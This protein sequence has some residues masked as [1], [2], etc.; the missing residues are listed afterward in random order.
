MLKFINDN[1]VLFS[2]VFSI[3]TA[4]IA[5]IVAIIID[6]KKSKQDTIR[7]L[8]KELKET[9][10]ELQQCRAIVDCYN[11]IEN[12]EKNIDKSN[13]AIYV[14]TLPDGKKRNICGY[15]WEN[16]HIKSPL[17]T[18]VSFSTTFQQTRRSGY[19]ALCKT[20]CYDDKVD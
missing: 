18:E 4:L 6:N 12:A 14:E 5:A 16:K 3:I 1:G 15:C 9:N 13:G 2:G 8:K 10:Q 20:K 7:N 19:C 17:R 11:S